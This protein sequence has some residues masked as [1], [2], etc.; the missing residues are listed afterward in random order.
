MAFRCGG[1]VEVAV[2]VDEAVVVVDAA[3][4]VV[5]NEVEAEEAAYC[6]MAVDGRAK[7][8]VA[9]A[10]VRKRV[11]ECIVGMM[12]QCREGRGGT[13]GKRDWEKRNGVN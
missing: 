11:M 3:A 12:I 8:D 10:I 4:V 9:R 1:A 13:R 6:G 7:R 5:D 2:A